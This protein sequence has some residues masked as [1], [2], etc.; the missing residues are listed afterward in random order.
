MNILELIK[1]FVKT[2]FD[3]LSDA[4][5]EMLQENVALLSPS[6]LKKFD[7]EQ[8][9]DDDDD[10]NSGDD[11]DDDD[12]DDSMDEKSLK[13]MISK[14]IETEMGEKMDEK[15]DAIA[16]KLVAKFLVRAK[17]QRSK[18]IDIG[19]K[20]LEVD[21]NR[22]DTRDFLKA[23]LVKD[24]KTLMEMEK[25]TTTYNYTGDDARG[26]YTIPEELLVEVLR[27]AE[28][29]YGL[30]RRD[31]RYLP[32]SGPGNE[33]KIP[34]L[35]S[36]VT[37]YWID[38][39]ADKTSSNPTFGLV[40]QTLKKLA[41]IVPLTEELIED[42]AVNLTSLVAELVAEAMAKEEDTQ[43]F[44]GSGSP[45]TGILQNGSVSSVSLG[46]GVGV[47]GITFAYLID[48][49]DEIAT[50]ALAGAKYYM[51]RTIYS[52]LRKLRADAVSADDGKGVFLL[53]PNK[54]DIEGILEFPIEFSDA[55]PGKTFATADSAFCFFGNLKIAAI[56]GDKR[57]MRAKLLSEA[58]ITDGDGT[59]TLNLAMQNMIALRIE[60]RVGYVL[61]L[62]SAIVVL[63][64]GT[65][66]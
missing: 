16:D 3:E 5:K 4:E 45:W 55:L 52:Y 61:A 56:F 44:N 54:T 28:K 43:F 1:K 10:D 27:I 42:S 11:D 64:T 14:N 29:Q 9:S 51:N 22:S 37:V 38:E 35:A 18:A 12:D 24:T 49:Q 23:L 47:S 21:P 58:T 63:K 20:D 26:G 6:Q 36:S 59:T 39:A 13:E 15:M 62:P 25:K 40:T 50:G 31:M 7:D 2:S 17:K 65:A 48:M 34:T 60:E 57:A 46:A 66:S 32:F 19:K 41:A 33:R 8:S 30:A 53:P